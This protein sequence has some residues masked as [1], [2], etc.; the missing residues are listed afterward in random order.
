MP[1]IT[2]PSGSA[3]S[4]CLLS[5][6]HAHTIEATVRSVLRQTVAGYEIII[7]DD[8]STDGTWE[9]VQSLAAEHPSI[10]ALRTPH[11]MGMAA[12]ANYAVEQSERAYIALLHHDDV[13]RED[14]LEK[15]A[16][17]LDRHADV[18]FVFNPYQDYTSGH[19][20]QEPVPGERIDGKWLLNHY[21]FGRWGCLIRGTAMVRREA[22]RAI[23]GMRPRFGML[24]DID[25]WM[26]LAMRW[27]VGYVAEPVILMREEKP[28]YYPKEYQHVEWSWKRQGILYD[29]HA[30]NRLEYLKL[31]TVRGRLQ[32]WKFRMRVAAE[33]TKWLG[34]GVVYRKPK[35]L[36][37]SGQGASPHD[38]WPVRLG[39]ALLQ[40]VYGGA[41]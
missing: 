26:R 17:V 24:A 3:V 20:Y 22:W 41:Q 30:T 36:R 12:N 15:W 31:G 18:A 25:M 23:G 9:K 4:V 34:Y 16:G 28:E 32:W 2:P 1:D 38:L 6:N 33:T 29:I 10:R 11:N 21:L 7:S 27:N 5:Y 40:R 13:Y 8:C 37:T 39:R 19:I 14:L 35:V